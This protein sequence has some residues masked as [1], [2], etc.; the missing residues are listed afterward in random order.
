MKKNAFTPYIYRIFIFANRFLHTEGGW[1]EN[2]TAAKE[3]R[4][5]LA[6]CALPTSLLLQ[7]EATKGRVFKIELSKV[8]GNA[9]AAEICTGPHNRLLRRQ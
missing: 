6:V 2:A 1:I 5:M 9:L 8:S 3:R 4:A 7:K